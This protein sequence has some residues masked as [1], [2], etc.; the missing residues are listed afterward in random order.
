M[1]TN[2]NIFDYLENPPFGV[3]QNVLLILILL[4]VLIT[5]MI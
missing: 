5:T 1:L 4:L 3:L 2:K